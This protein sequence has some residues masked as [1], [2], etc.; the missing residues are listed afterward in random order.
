[1][2]KENCE[3]KLGG[4]ELFVEVEFEPEVPE[5]AEVSAKGSLIE[6]KKIL[7]RKENI[8]GFKGYIDVTDLLGECEDAFIMIENKC[9][10]ELE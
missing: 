4:Q 6:I 9:L 5:T 3:I 7:W 2:S 10:K 1:M 8:H